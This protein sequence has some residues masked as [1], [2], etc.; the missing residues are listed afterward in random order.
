MRQLFC[1]GIS[2]SALF[3]MFYEM[4]G[5][6]SCISYDYIK[7]YTW[8]GPWRAFPREVTQL[9]VMLA[10]CAYPTDYNM[11]RRHRKGGGGEGVENQ[12]DSIFRKYY[13]LPC[14]VGEIVMSS[15]CLRSQTNPEP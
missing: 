5:D 13:S 1:F 7:R 8:K 9:L 3:C 4:K 6:Y 2:I 14:Q 15:F 11:T 10:L 12:I